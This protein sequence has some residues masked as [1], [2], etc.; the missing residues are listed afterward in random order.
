[1]SVLDSGEVVSIS[2]SPQTIREIALA[3]TDKPLTDD[4]CVRIAHAIADRIYDVAEGV[5]D[6][7]IAT[8]LRGED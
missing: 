3:H 7:A 2:I 8:E 4:Q 1:M 5:Y 6:D